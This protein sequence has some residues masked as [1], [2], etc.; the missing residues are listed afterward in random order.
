[1]KVLKKI[2]KEREQRIEK[3]EKLI[4]ELDDDLFNQCQ[5]LDHFKSKLNNGQTRLD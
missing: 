2:I 1:M 5:E 4:K 3:L